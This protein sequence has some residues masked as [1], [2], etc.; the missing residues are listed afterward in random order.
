MDFK[1]AAQKATVQHCL[2]AASATTN[3]PRKMEDVVQMLNKLD[4]PLHRIFR[5]NVCHV[6]LIMDTL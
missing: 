4:A 2:E 3:A 5:R 6:L 1:S